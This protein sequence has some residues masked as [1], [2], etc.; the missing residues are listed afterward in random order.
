MKLPENVD[1]EAIKNKMID[2]TNAKR[3]VE[4]LNIIDPDGRYMQ[5]LARNRAAFDPTSLKND[6]VPIATIPAPLEDFLISMH[7]EDFWR[8]PDFWKK[9]P[10]YLERPVAD[11]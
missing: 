10:E 2:S 1:P 3:R 11:L 9:H 8:D 7:G 4:L 5:Q 6:M